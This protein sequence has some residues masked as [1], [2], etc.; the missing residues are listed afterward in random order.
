MKNL[1]YLI[2]AGIIALSGCNPRIPDIPEIPSIPP[3]PPIP[4]ED[5]IEE[6]PVGEP[7]EDPIEEP[8]PVRDDFYVDISFK[9]HRVGDRLNF[10]G[11][12]QNKHLEYILMSNETGGLEW[13]LIKGER[14][15]DK[16]TLEETYSITLKEQG[17]L[18]VEQFDSKVKL[19]TEN[20]IIEY[21]GRRYEFPFPISLE[22]DGD[23]PKLTEKGWYTLAFLMKYVFEGED[24]SSRYES[25]FEVS[26]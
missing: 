13:S 20:T 6:D 22:F 2:G 3:I 18:E 23:S 15:V 8:E 5:P 7:I 25:E 21:D 10:S 19:T 14:V 26:E 4:I 16:N 11:R 24:Y 1:K 12:I 9:D 17:Y